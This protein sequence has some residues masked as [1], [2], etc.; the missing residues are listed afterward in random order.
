L[1]RFQEVLRF[2]EKRSLPTPMRHVCNSGGIVNLPEAHFDMVRPGV[3][4]YGIYPG[5][6]GAKVNVKPAHMEIEGGV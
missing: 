1:E 3:L 4:F 2:Y 5:R 6:D